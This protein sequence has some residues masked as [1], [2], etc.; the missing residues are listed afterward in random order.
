[1]MSRLRTV[2]LLVIVLGR[3]GPQLLVGQCGGWLGSGFVLFH[4][5]ELGVGHLCLRFVVAFNGR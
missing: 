1:M 4:L 2:V 3:L 5:P